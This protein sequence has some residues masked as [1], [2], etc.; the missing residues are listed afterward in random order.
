M[1]CS[2]MEEPRYADPEK[3]KDVKRENFATEEEAIKGAGTD[4]LSI[5]PATPILTVEQLK[6]ATTP[7]PRTKGEHRVYAGPYHA[8]NDE[9]NSWIYKQEAGEVNG[10][11]DY[12]EEEEPEDE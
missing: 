3:Y 9:R 11:A 8:M 2:S 5:F 12:V 6:E 1:R 4:V 10:P 7:P